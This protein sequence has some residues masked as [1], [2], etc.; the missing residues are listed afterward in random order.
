MKEKR[1]RIQQIVHRLGG[2]PE[3]AGQVSLRYFQKQGL[4]I[5]VVKYTNQLVAGIA[6]VN[7]YT[8]PNGKPDQF[9]RKTGAAI[10][11]GR[12]TL[13]SENKNRFILTQPGLLNPWGRPNWFVVTE[14]IRQLT[15]QQPATSGRWQLEDAL[16]SILE[17]YRKYKE[18]P[19][20]KP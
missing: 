5:A 2:P 19:T 16:D 10:A 13:E 6:K 7:E 8:P 14:N 4:T 20:S 3:E 17:G 15:S 1:N 11:I 12:A 18:T 9:C